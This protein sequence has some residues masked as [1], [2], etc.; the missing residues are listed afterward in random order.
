MN[1]LLRIACTLL[2]AACALAS[3]P[4]HAGRSCE[5]KPLATAALRDGLALAE[6]TARALDAS[7]ARVVV[8]ARA[9]QD[10]SR[11]G[12][13]WSH[14]GL[15]YRD[16]ASGYW[17]VVHKLNHCGS[18][19]ASLYRQGLGEFFLD[20]P[21]RYEAAIVPLR[22]D[23]QARLLALLADDTRAARLHR[24]AYSMVAY[25][26]A[27]TYQQSNQWVIE[28]LAA[29]ADPAVSSRTQAQAWLRRHDYRPAPLR[30]D[31]L[32]RLGA[33]VARANVAFD[34]HPPSQ[35]FAGR[36]ETVSADSVLQWLAHSGLGEPMHLLR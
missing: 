33:S 9:G 34:D 7:G 2:A 1:R 6:R 30:I 20:D 13:R 18:A 5:D 15:A 24:D 23:L 32:E 36:I 14:V 31:T 26:W 11:W 22:A 16:A 35:R 10:L 4:A 8:L 27:A 21:W 19:S 25:P 29:A 28:T 12:L 17:R 3:A